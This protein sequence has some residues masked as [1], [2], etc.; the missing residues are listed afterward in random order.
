MMDLSELRERLEQA[1]GPSRELDAEIHLALF[2]K[3]KVNK[4]DPARWMVSPVHRLPDY[5]FSL[6][7][8]LALVERVLPQSGGWQ[9]GV[10]QGPPGAR[11]WCAWGW[12]RGIGQV[13]FTKRPT[14][15][16]ALLIAL[17]RAMEADRRR[18]AQGEGATD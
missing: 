9:F 14:A 8:A 15:P 11:V 17:T 3:A 13:G 10:Y 18:A 1:D 4:S 5:T 12:K 7:A 2:P 16:L 6:D